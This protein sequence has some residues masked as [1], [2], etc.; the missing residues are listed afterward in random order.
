MPWTIKDP[1]NVAKNWTMKQK[2][3]CV[4]AANAVL[5]EGGKDDKAIFACIAAAGKTKRRSE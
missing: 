4:A 1:P 3:Q 5:S 2:Q